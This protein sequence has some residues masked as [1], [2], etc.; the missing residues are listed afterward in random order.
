M[1]GE[2]RGQRKLRQRMRTPTPRNPAELLTSSYHNYRH[3]KR[4]HVRQDLRCCTDGSMD[5]SFVV[6]FE[7]DVGSFLQ[8][9]QEARVK[10]AYREKEIGEAEVLRN[11]VTQLN[12]DLVANEAR[13]DQL[14]QEISTRKAALEELA[15]QKTNADSA[16]QVESD[17]QEDAGFDNGDASSTATLGTRACLEVIQS[18]FE[19][20]ISETQEFKVEHSGTTQA[21]TSVDK[22]AGQS[23]ALEAFDDNKQIQQVEETAAEEP[24]G[25]DPI[26]S[27][28]PEA[29]EQ[30]AAEE[31]DATMEEDGKVTYLVHVE[32][33]DATGGELR[34]A[35]VKAAQ[36][37]PSFMVP[38]MP[39][40]T[41]SPMEAAQMQQQ[42]AKDEEKSEFCWAQVKAA[43]AKPP[44][45]VLPVPAPTMSPME[46]AKQERKKNVQPKKPTAKN[47]APGPMQVAPGPVPKEAPP[48]IASSTEGPPLGWNFTRPGQIHYDK[49]PCQHE[50]FEQSPRSSQRSARGQEKTSNGMDAIPAGSL[51]KSWET[52]LE[53]YRRQQAGMQ[54]AATK[55]RPDI[56]AA[57]RAIELNA[58]AH[59]DPAALKQLTSK[60]HQGRARRDQH[61]RHS[62]GSRRR[63]LACQAARGLERMCRFLG[64]LCGVRHTQA[65]LAGSGSGDSIQRRRGQSYQQASPFQRSWRCLYAI[66]SFG[67]VCTVQSLNGQHEALSTCSPA[68]PV[69]AYG[70]HF[71]ACAA[72]RVG[73]LTC[74]PMFG[75]DACLPWNHSV[76]SEHDYICPFLAV[77]RAQKMRHDLLFT[78]DDDAAIGLTHHVGIPLACKKLTTTKLTTKKMF[79]SSKPGV[80]FH[81]NVSLLMGSDNDLQM[82]DTILPHSALIDWSD[83]PWQLWQKNRNGYWVRCAPPSEQAVLSS[84][85]SNPH[86]KSVSNSPIL[87]VPHQSLR[88]TDLHGHVEGLDAAITQ[89]Q[90]TPGGVDNLQPPPEAPAF[91]RH[92]LELAMVDADIDQDDLTFYVRT[93][94]INHENHPKCEFPRI[95]ELRSDWHTWHR[96]ILESWRDRLEIDAAHEIHVVRPDPP[97][98]A[99]YARALV[100]LIIT[101]GVDITGYAGLVRVAPISP[102]IEPFF[103]VAYSFPAEVSGIM[104]RAAADA[105]YICMQR[106]CT[107]YHGW[108]EVPQTFDLVHR[109]SHGDSLVIF[110]T[111]RTHI[112]AASAPEEDVPLDFP[113][114]DGSD[115]ASQEALEDRLRIR[116]RTHHHLLPAHMTRGLKVVLHMARVDLLMLGRVQHY[117]QVHHDRC[118]V[119]VDHHIWPHQDIGVR[120]FLHGQYVRLAVPPAADTSTDTQVAIDI[121]ENAVED[122]QDDATPLPDE[123]VVDA[124]HGHEAQPFTAAARQHKPNPGTEPPDVSF[125]LPPHVT[126]EQPRVRSD[127][128]FDWMHPLSCSFAEAGCFER[129]TGI[130]LEDQALTWLDDLRRAWADVLDPTFPLSIWLIHPRPPQWRDHRSVC[131]ILLEQARPANKAAGVLTGLMEG[132]SVDGIVQGAFSVPRPAS[133]TVALNLLNIERFSHDRRITFSHGSHVLN[134]HDDHDLPSGFSVCIRLHFDQIQTHFEDLALMQTSTIVKDSRVRGVDVPPQ[135]RECENFVF[136]PAATEFR[137]PNVPL[138]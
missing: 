15:A 26:V 82:T 102:D 51:L 71:G 75:P 50:S 23:A 39:A 62:S 55:A 85:H 46:A 53:G 84:V 86:A 138:E 113:P 56:A 19:R 123:V 118:V 28:E 9:N 61:R 132:V 98:H 27:R 111:S 128:V 130:T 6:M 10:E 66:V 94:F 91:M 100:D 101:T 107:V 18:G 5:P 22:T 117:C 115:Q 120:E 88:L 106:R 81:D 17:A 108:T 36:A 47:D 64:S 4:W 76:R 109:M 78:N 45:M 12:G 34:W 121:I 33:S 16:T 74:S 119:H 99:R 80:H 131:H 129:T 126:P 31:A 79:T 57:R 21:R 7:V 41:M 30:E 96:E 105:D 3:E 95:V 103:S 90:E 32:D 38:P 124:D 13:N 89:N 122:A 49:Y 125:V 52:S 60:K 54:E 93:W 65:G 72:S 40:P 44:P 1:H 20:A 14:L 110:H 24:E 92:L 43:P 112:Q 135:E 116:R 68:F 114:H 137:M 136:N 97:R 69:E 29:A 67:R 104:T 35:Q 70:G 87:Q 2:M 42:K 77:L 73:R 25:S 83:K 48:L 37:K 11:K 127:G 58:K 59:G 134:L 133:Y 63:V 8:A